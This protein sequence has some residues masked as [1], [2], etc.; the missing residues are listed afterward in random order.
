MAQLIL[1]SVSACTEGDRWF[2]GFAGNA[3]EQVVGMQRQAVP[4]KIL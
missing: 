1:G 2:A 3:T 4:S